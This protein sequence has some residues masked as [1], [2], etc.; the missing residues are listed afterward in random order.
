M[1]RGDLAAFVRSLIFFTRDTFFLLLW[2]II[3]RRDKSTT[4]CGDFGYISID[5]DGF[6]CFE[7]SARIFEL[8]S[9]SH[10]VVEVRWRI[11]Q[12]GKY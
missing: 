2:W 5:F 6:S 11:F 7:L 9:G 12:V 1:L 8:L 10:R 4:Y 3:K